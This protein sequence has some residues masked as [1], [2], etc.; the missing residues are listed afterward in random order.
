MLCY[1]GDLFNAVDFGHCVDVNNLNCEKAFDTQAE[2]LRSARKCFV[3]DWELSCK[4][5]SQD[6][7]W[8][9]MLRPSANAK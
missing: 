7:H 4:Q 6:M 9:G 5:V 3:L 1:L 8:E 2:G